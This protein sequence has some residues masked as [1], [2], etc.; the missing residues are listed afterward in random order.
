MNIQ[1]CQ[2]A[3][4]QG[5]IKIPPGVVVGF[6]LFLGA[7]ASSLRMQE[8]ADSKPEI[9]GS[10]IASQDSTSQTSEINQASEGTQ[11][12]Q[13]SQFDET[14]QKRVAVLP[15]DSFGIPEADS[16]AITLFVETSLQKIGAFRIVEQTQIERVLVAQEYSASVPFDGTTALQVGRLLAA[17]SVLIGTAGRLV[18]RYYIHVK[19]V[20]VQTGLNLTS[21]RAEA[22]SLTLLLSLID[23]LCRRVCGQNTTEP[24]ILLQPGANPKAVERQ[25]GQW[26]RS[27]LKGNIEYDRDNYRDAYMFYLSALDEGCDDG[28]VFYRLAYASEKVFGLVE[29]TIQLYR[30]AFASLAVEYPLH[31]YTEAAK[32]KSKQ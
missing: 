32:R 15:F 8:P 14:N 7:C 25:P 28:I 23:P 27:A 24:L 6:C 30:R 3:I 22:T 4:L 16:K 10:P 26:L 18:D 9:P 2:V 19:L 17:D 11:S 13:V 1:M 5:A 12:N 21:E 29:A 31:R 20:D